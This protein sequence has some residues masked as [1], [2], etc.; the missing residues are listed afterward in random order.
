MEKRKIIRDFIGW[1][2]EKD[3]I[4][5]LTVDYELAETYLDEINYDY[6]VDS[7]K[8]KCSNCDEICEPISKGSFC[9]KCM[10]DL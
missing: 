9:D 8:V 4:D 3:L 1:L 2:I 7:S 10:C 6:K 5:G